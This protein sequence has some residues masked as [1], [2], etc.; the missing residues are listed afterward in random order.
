MNLATP[1]LICNQNENFRSLLREM[2]IKHGFFHV[3]EASSAFELQEIIKHQKQSHFIIIQGS[4]IVKDVIDL[5][6]NKNFIIIGQANDEAIVA[7]AARFGV[8]HFLSFPF[9]S[10][11]LFDKIQELS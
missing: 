5:R 1:F 8:K 6:T 9:S 3:L 4:L 7:L 10:Q 11:N 2:L